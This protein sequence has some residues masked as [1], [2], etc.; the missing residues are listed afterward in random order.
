[1]LPCA[2]RLGYEKH[3]VAIEHE[4]TRQRDHCQ[5]ADT[6]TDQTSL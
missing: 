6:M 3:T 1:M 4:D 2:T 5:L